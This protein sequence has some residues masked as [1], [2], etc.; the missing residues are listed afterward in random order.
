MVEV[1]EKAHR[2][3]NVAMQARSRITVIEQ[4]VEDTGVY[5]LEPVK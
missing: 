1:A 3:G 2:R 5:V 4:E